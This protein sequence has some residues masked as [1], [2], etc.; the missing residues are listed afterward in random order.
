M[1]K[2][3]CSLVCSFEELKGSATECVD[4]N[5]G[6]CKE[7]NKYSSVDVAPKLGVNHVISC[8]VVLLCRFCYVV[9]CIDK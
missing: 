4:R 5:C 7:L 1:I 3:I 8:V 9:L 2:K 6:S